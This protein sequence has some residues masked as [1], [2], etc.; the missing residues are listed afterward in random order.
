MLPR[1][2]SDTFADESFATTDSWR[3]KIALAQLPRGGDYSWL[4]DLRRRS[5]LPATEAVKWRHLAPVLRNERHG[6]IAQGAEVTLSKALISVLDLD[7]Y[8]SMLD[9]DTTGPI[10]RALAD[11]AICNRIIMDEPT[12]QAAWTGHSPTVVGRDLGLST[13]QREENWLDAARQGLGLK[14]SLVSLEGAELRTAMIGAVIVGDRRPEKHKRLLMFG[15]SGSA[16]L[17][18]WFDDAAWDRA[19]GA[20]AYRRFLFPGDIKATL[21]PL[22]RSLRVPA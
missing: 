5:G 13:A 12:L 3:S 17:T 21:L 18:D 11:D 22:Y 7:Q 1:Q 6:E 8:R 9:F 16:T 19:F 14:R 10:G 15:L 20:L 4:H 2:H